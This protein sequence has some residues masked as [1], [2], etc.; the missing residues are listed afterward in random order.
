MHIC[1]NCVKFL[2]HVIDNLGIRPDPTRC[3]RLIHHTHLS[4]RHPTSSGD[5]ESNV[6]ISPRLA[7]YTQPL[8]EL[9]VRQS[10]GLGVS[11]TAG[12]S[13]NKADANF[14]SS[15][16]TRRPEFG[17]SS[18]TQHIIIRVGSSTSAETEIRTSGFCLQVYDS[19]GRT[20]RSDQ[21]RSDRCSYQ[22]RSDHTLDPSTTR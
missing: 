21:V 20:L 11:T 14:Q 3:C 15:S 18:L 8:R 13:E 16:R 19:H 4:W 12:L 10:M 2:G 22:V 7:D 9:R 5:G 1:A 17:D 6:Q